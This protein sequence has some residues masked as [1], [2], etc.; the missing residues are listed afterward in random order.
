V[1]VP[2]IGRELTGRLLDIWEG[3]SGLPPDKEEAYRRLWRGRAGNAADGT[4][5]A[6]T[7]VLVGRKQGTPPRSPCAHLGRT[8]TAPERIELGLAH[9]KNWHECDRGHGYVCQCAHCKTCP[10]YEPR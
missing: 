1:F 2:E 10:D 7:S 9:T 5:P 3:R 4:A 6:T 8:V